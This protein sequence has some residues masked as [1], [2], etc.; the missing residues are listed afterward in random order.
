MGNQQAK[1]NYFDEF[2]TEDGKNWTGLGGHLDEEP[3]DVKERFDDRPLV[4]FPKEN[5]MFAKSMFKASVGDWIV[6]N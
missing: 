5:M 2:K 4:M 1:K 6:P 3:F